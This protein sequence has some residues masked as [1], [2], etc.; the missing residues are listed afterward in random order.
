MGAESLGTRLLS[1]V[2]EEGLDEVRSSPVEIIMRRLV[3]TNRQFLQSLRTSLKYRTQN[4]LGIQALDRLL[5]IFADSLQSRERLIPPSDS[6]GYQQVHTSKKVQAPVI[7]I[8]G[9]APC[10]GKTQ[11]LYYIAALSLLPETYNEVP[12]AGKKGAVIWIDTNNRFDVLRF[13]D[14]ILGHV[15]SCFQDILQA[16]DSAREAFQAFI[17]T[18]LGHFYL[19][20]VSSPTS[21]LATVQQIPSNF[22]DSNTTH[23]SSNRPIQTLILSDLSSF[24]WQNRMEEEIQA[25]E[26]GDSTRPNT[27]F[28]HYRDLVESLREVQDTFDCTIVTTVWGLSSLQRTPRP[29]LRPHLPAV[30]SNFCTLKLIAER[31]RVSK[32]VPG[33]SAQEAVEEATRRQ[34]AVGKGK[35]SCWVNHWNDQVWNGDV[36]ANLQQLPN[37]GAFSFQIRADGLAISN[38]AS[39]D[40]TVE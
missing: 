39:V 25:A 28:Q 17:Q 29:S 34:E 9:A 19:F 15:T 31:D 10:S 4:K 20:R 37:H 21:L 2:K 24:L 13:R 16:Q 11:L 30:W 6:T 7:E 38:D 8:A 23:R 12:L 3:L 36:K 1:E 33:M 35:F 14:I 27:F 5:N 32:F 40:S 26:R 22:L 18:A